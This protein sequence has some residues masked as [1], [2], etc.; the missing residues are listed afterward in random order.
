MKYLLA[1]VGL[2]VGFSAHAQTSSLQNKAQVV[3]ACTVT[4]VQHI[5]FPPINTLD[6][7]TFYT[8][9]GAVAVDCTKGSYAVTINGG[10][11][12]LT[13]YN[14]D[15][16]AN[17]YMYSF[18]CN[19]RMKSG[20]NYISYSLY[21]QE[22]SRVPNSEQFVGTDRYA[23]IKV[24]TPNLL[25]QQQTDSYGSTSCNQAANPYATLVFDQKGSVILP[26]TA[27]LNVAKGTI[28]GTYVDTLA[29]TVVF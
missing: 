10:N 21:P 29:M 1:A 8:A 14:R 24:S 4:T 5:S 26:V 12:N 27:Q 28:M 6:N 11:N 19:R 15:L 17:T 23:S 25:S 18:Y 3:S 9:S 22:A 13:G 20:A 16:V 7:T 2:V